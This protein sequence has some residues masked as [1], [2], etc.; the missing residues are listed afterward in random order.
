MLLSA[1]PVLIYGRMSRNFLE[2]AQRLGG[3]MASALSVLATKPGQEGSSATRLDD[4]QALKS[5]STP[6]LHN[7][8]S[9]MRSAVRADDPAGASS[10]SPK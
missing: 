3:E 1:A 2:Q 9:A 4:A 7:L 5:G 6:L 10:Q 8:N